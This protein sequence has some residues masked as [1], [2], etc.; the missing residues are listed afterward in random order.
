[1]YTYKALQTPTQL[2]VKSQNLLSKI[3]NRIAV[4][5]PYFILENLSFEGNYLSASVKAETKLTLETNP[6]T[7]IE[8]GRHSAIL[9]TALLALLQKDNQR[10]Y[11]LANK[12]ESNAQKNS[13]PFGAPVQFQA[14]KVELTKKHAKVFVSSTAYDQHLANLTISYTILTE[15]LFQRLF[16]FYKQET[17]VVISPYKKV[18]KESFEY[19]DDWAELNLVISKSACTGHFQNYP[20]IPVA[21]LMGQLSYMAGQ[22]FGKPY[23][24]KRGIVEANN[25]CWAGQKVHFRVDLIEHSGNT[26]V[27]N[28]HASVENEI[29]GKMSVWLSAS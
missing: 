13:I 2:P 20:V 22:V 7:G 19:G 6:M 8:I 9:G 14:K 28:C 26:A 18:L 25:L 15:H 29:V 16:H 4:Q 10:R 3:L 11:Y 12:A 24:Y 5:P 17:P 1:M 23:W 27:F 21:K